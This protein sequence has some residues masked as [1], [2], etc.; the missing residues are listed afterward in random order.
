MA[1]ISSD[2]GEKVTC[3]QINSRFHSEKYTN[4]KVRQKKEKFLF[5]YE[6]R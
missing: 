3:A 6:H 4:T 1:N 5:H 2:E